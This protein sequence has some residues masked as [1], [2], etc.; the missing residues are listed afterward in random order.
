MSALVRAFRAESG[1]AA[2]V[3]EDLQAAALGDL[4]A[5]LYERGR[6]A[7]PRLAVPES[8]FGR[9]LARCAADGDTESLADL[10]AEDVYLAC[11][12]AESVRGA[13]AAFDR[14]YRRIIRR[15][16]SRVLS[17]PDE[18]QEA[19]QRT[20]QHLLVGVGDKP[21][22]ITQYLGQGRL[23]KWISVA[24]TRVAISFARGEIVEHRMRKKAIT[25]VAG[26]DAEHLLMKGQLRE[27]VEAA[28]GRGLARLKPRE[29]L[30][31][32]LYLVSGMTLTAIGRSL[33]VTRQAVTKTLGQARDS[34]LGE[35]EGSLRD[36]MKMSKSDLSSVLRLVASELDVNIS[37]VLGA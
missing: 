20:W 24:S 22:R 1:A 3:A 28:V 36:Q 16:V 13:V 8:A 14:Q 26:G 35:V 33:G 18:Q 29:Q 11:G 2:A 9:W 6:Q 27:S 30:V 10:L 32:K 31:L 34:I 19:E 21:P 15:A 23:E 5:A 25:E 17:A 37:R 12:C 7:Y 4:L